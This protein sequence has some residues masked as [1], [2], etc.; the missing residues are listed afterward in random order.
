MKKSLSQFSIL[1]LRAKKELSENLNEAIEKYRNIHGVQ[2]KVVHSN[3]NTAAESIEAGNIS[4]IFSETIMEKA[5]ANFFKSCLV[6]AKEMPFIICATDN[7]E[8]IHDVVASDRIYCQ[9]GDFSFAI[10]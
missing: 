7:Y 3:V 2:I 5:E 6:S 8:K 4:L 10:F 1:A 9:K